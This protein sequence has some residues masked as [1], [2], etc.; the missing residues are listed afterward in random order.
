[1]LLNIDKPPANTVGQKFMKIG[2]LFVGQVL[3]RQE[4]VSCRLLIGSGSVEKPLEEL[5]SPRFA[6]ETKC[7]SSGFSTSPDPLRS[8]QEYI[9]SFPSLGFLCC[10]EISKFQLETDFISKIF[11]NFCIYI[12][13]ECAKLQRN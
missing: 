1:M 7:S 2:G 4:N 8:L 9:F 6:R 13:C 10:Y 11:V 3:S 5:V 12:L